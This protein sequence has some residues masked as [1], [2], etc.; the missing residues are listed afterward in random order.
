M[1][2]IICHE[3]RSME[4]LTVDEKNIISK[5]EVLIAIK[6]IGICGTDIHAYGGNQPYFEYPRVLGHE[7]SGIVEEVGESVQDIQSG[8]RVTIVPYVH[9]GICI[10]C[11]QGRTNCCTS[12]QVIGVHQ[13][14][15]M[16]EYL[17]VPQENVLTVNDL[18]LESAATIEPLSIGAH[19][20]RRAGVQKEDTV[21]VIGAG[22]IG[23]GVARFTKLIGAKTILMD[24]S[25][26]RLAF[27]QQWTEADGT[28]KAGEHAFDELLSLNNQELPTVVI[29]AT[30]NKQSMEQAFTYVS[31]GG[32]LVYVGLVKDRISFSDP[33]FHSKEL[34][35]LGSR[36]ATIEDF[37]HVID[38]MAKGFIKE[39]YI[40]NR[41]K[42]VEVPT[43]FAAN[44]FRTNKTMISI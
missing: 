13:D 42:F 8:D 3:P 7:L 10:A 40:T 22:P 39:G 28:V 41:I 35:L 4:L 16:S 25:E 18:S 19:A 11:R 17:K 21:L 20:V 29:D 44:D 32:K 27:S 6:H 33:D 1:R 2:K 24:I 30:G 38:C 12:M 9:C 14:G 36:N 34:T 23:L 31:H 43:F 26:E 15:G 5:D 37:N